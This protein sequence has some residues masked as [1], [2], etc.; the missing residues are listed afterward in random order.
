MEINKL[1]II[2]SIDSNPFTLK[3]VI[4]VEIRLIITQL[5]KTITELHP[6]KKEKKIKERKKK[7]EKKGSENK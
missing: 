7:T 4:S 3:S 1:A 5:S 6:R 2:D